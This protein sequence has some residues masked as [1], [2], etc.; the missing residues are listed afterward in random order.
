MQGSAARL[1]RLIDLSASV[2]Q[3]HGALVPP[4]SSRIVQRCPA[5]RRNQGGDKL[6]VWRSLVEIKPLES[7]MSNKQPGTY[8]PIKS[9][10]FKSVPLLKSKFRHST[11]LWG[12]KISFSFESRLTCKTKVDFEISLKCS[13]EWQLIQWIPDC[14]TYYW[15]KKKKENR[16]YW[17]SKTFKIYSKI[18]FPNT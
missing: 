5:R 13:L 18:Y 3:G 7:M 17:N 11:F 15:L 1:V 2:H 14:W 10:L 6:T 9:L 12:Q 16:L 8:L 4:I